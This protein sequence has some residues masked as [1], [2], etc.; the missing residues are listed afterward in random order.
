MLPTL[1]MRIHYGLVIIDKNN[2]N[3]LKIDDKKQSINSW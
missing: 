1:S 2:M 3:L